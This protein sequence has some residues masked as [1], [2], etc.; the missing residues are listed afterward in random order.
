MSGWTVHP[1]QN[2]R[3]GFKE[4]EMDD[5]RK[6]L[7]DDKIAKARE[8]R[9]S[10]MSYVQIGKEVGASDVCVRTY[11]MDI[12]VDTKRKMPEAVCCPSCEQKLPRKAR[13]CYMCGTKILTEKEKVIQN[14]EKVRNLVV[15]LPETR[16]DSTLEAINNAVKY[17]K[18]LEDK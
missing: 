18:S 4:R 6:P 16:R 11:C 10:G 15:F 8:L 17:L 7:S 5:M 13:F 2:E 12:D 1:L 14:L 3:N 9:A